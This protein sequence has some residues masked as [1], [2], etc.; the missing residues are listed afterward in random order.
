MHQN[1][2]PSPQHV[3]VS[4]P[5]LAEC[6]SARHSSRSEC[7]FFSL[8]NGLA[9]IICILHQDVGVAAFGSMGSE[10]TIALPHPNQYFAASGRHE[11]PEAAVD[12]SRSCCTAAQES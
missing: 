12:A 1:M 5:K 11:R 7:Y 10:S 3:D 8:Q 9:A 6:E 4:L 2:K